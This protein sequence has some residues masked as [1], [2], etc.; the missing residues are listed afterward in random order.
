VFD[1]WV[2]QAFGVSALLRQLFGYRFPPAQPVEHEGNTH[3]TTCLDLAP[4][5]AGNCV[6][7]HCCS[8]TSFR[9]SRTRTRRPW[10]GST[11]FRAE[12]R[13]EF[14]G[15]SKC[16]RGSALA[17][18]RARTSSALQRAPDADLLRNPLR[19]GPPPPAYAVYSVGQLELKTRQSLSG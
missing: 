19:S 2:G 9:S 14:F 13:T 8:L 12:W 17:C 10:A 5:S 6:G 16:L 11:P 4:V 3:L 7:S 15:L 1:R 18:L